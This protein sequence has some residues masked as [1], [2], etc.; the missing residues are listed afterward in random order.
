MELGGSSSGDIFKRIRQK[1]ILI[2]LQPPPYEACM[3]ENY[4]TFLFHAKLAKLDFLPLSCYRFLAVFF[5]FRLDICA[6]IKVFLFQ[7]LIRMKLIFV[8]A[9]WPSQG[10]L[11]ALD[12][13]TF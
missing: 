10:H 1:G 6:N 11:Q 13:V 5:L 7:L 12:F 2:F 9:H 8:L 3:R 4:F